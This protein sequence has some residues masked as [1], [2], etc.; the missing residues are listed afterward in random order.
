VG[1]V[2]AHG[3]DEVRDQVGAALVD[4]Q[5][6]RPGG[7]HRFVLL[8]DGVVTAATEHRGERDQDQRHEELAHQGSP[9]LM[10]VTHCSIGW[11]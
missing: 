6:L 2:A 10:D 8:L 9:R 3:R 1:G 11:N 7:L 4:V 5:H